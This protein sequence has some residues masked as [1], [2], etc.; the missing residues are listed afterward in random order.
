MLR[1]TNRV[2]TLS[3]F[4]IMQSLVTLCTSTSEKMILNSIILQFRL[5]DS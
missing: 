1:V 4:M 5:L 2:R 3:S